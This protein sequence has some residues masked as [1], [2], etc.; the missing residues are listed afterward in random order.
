MSGDEML[1]QRR[2]YQGRDVG[3]CDLCGAIVPES[4]LREI[5]ADATYAGD[6][7]STRICK[8]CWERI[9]RGEIDVESLL[10][11]ED[12]RDMARGPVPW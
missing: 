8:D 6:F 5:E 11:E 7:E 3:H 2:E 9:H 12:E 4:E 1:G 10:I